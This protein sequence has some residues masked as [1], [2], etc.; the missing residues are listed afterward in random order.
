MIIGLERAPRL[1]LTWLNIFPAEGTKILKHALCN[2]FPAEG[3]KILKHALCHAYEHA[4]IVCLNKQDPNDQLLFN[5][6]SNP[7]TVVN[8]IQFLINNLVEKNSFKK[9]NYR[10]ILWQF[11]FVVTNGGW[12]TMTTTRAVLLSKEISKCLLMTHSCWFSFLPGV[13]L[14]V[15]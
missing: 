7:E 15:N 9:G 1:S 10:F 4:A 13:W 8:L 6:R 3:T 12:Q 11:E 5:T 14:A 2:I